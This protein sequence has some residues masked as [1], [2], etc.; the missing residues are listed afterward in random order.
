MT[1]S[2]I[3]S[4]YA[5]IRPRN[6]RERP[7]SGNDLFCNI[8]MELILVILKMAS[9]YPLAPF[10]HERCTGNRSRT[11]FTWWC[12]CRNVVA[13]YIWT[14]TAFIPPYTCMHFHFRVPI[15]IPVTYQNYQN[16]ACHT[17]RGL[18]IQLIIEL[19]ET[20]KNPQ[21]SKG[22]ALMPSNN[23]FC[24]KRIQFPVAILFS[25][26]ACLLNPRSWPGWDK[27]LV[28]STALRGQHVVKCVLNPRYLPPC[29]GGRGFN[30]LMHSLFD[31]ITKA[32]YLR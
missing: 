29:R 6:T 25:E 3:R 10:L 11:M 26:N 15:R 27:H 23:C 5:Y 28:N 31:S 21:I 12:G 32:F 24:R 13:F 18:K 4:W 17:Q 22:V 16:T 9:R 30:W 7:G 1:Y 14:V 19:L 2:Q 8:A 20:S